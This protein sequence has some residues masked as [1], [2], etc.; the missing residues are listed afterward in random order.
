MAARVAGNMFISNMSFYLLSKVADSKRTSK[1]LVK[2][3]RIGRPGILNFGKG[4][5]QGRLI[6][7]FQTF[8]FSKNGLWQNG[9]GR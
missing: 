1:G 9:S 6:S 7:K 8:A 3:C 2:V 5:L 4:R